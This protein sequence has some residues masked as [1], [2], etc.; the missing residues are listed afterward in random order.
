MLQFASDENFSGH[1]VRVLLTRLPTIDLI[2]VQDSSLYG[3]E[4]P[5]L[6]S[7]C[8][9]EN[10]LLLSHDFATLKD[11]AYE[12]VTAGLVMPGV[13]LCGQHAPPRIIADDLVLIATC[14]VPEDW[15]NNVWHLPL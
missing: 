12:R 13:L 8:A 1:I 15:A 4:D 6:L 11:F 10:R 3:A 2:R 9:E 14:S 5:E 7:W